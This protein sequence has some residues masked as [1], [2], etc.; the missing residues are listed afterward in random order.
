MHIFP[1]CL[2]WNSIIKYRFSIIC[3]QRVH[4][5]WQR[6]ALISQSCQ[7][8]TRMIIWVL[9]VLLFRRKS[10]FPIIIIIVTTP[11]MMVC[12]QHKSKSNPAGEG[13]KNYNGVSRLFFL[14]I[15]HKAHSSFLRQT[16]SHSLDEFSSERGEHSTSPPSLHGIERWEELRR[17]Q[18]YK[19]LWREFTIHFPLLS[20]LH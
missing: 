13:K 6:N 10:S 7:L 12:I 5:H 3:A 17:M 18:I 1:V 16:R 2:C 8:Q 4:W 11:L 20:K 14:L 15:C 19:L 9:G